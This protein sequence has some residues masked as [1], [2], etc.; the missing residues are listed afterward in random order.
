MRI[1]SKAKINKVLKN[2]SPIHLPRTVKD[3]GKKQKQ[4]RMET[5]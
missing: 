4:I 2:H 5:M 1:K 3:D